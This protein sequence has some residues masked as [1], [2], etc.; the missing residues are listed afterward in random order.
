MT[1]ADEHR[2]AF[3]HDWGDPRYVPT[4]TDLVLCAV[5]IGLVVWALWGCPGLL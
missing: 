4:P 2:H 3:D 1:T 5:G